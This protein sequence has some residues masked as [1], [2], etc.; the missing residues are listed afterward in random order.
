MLA[1]AAMARAAYQDMVRGYEQLAPRAAQKADTFIRDRCARRP[2]ARRPADDCRRRC[3]PSRSRQPFPGGGVGIAKIA[4]LDKGGQPKAKK[5]GEYWRAQE[6]G[7]EAHVGRIVPGFFM[8]GRSATIGRQFR[9]HPYFE[10]AKRGG[11]AG[12]RRREPRPWSS[13][14]RCMRAISCVTVR[15]PSRFGTH[16]KAIRIN[17]RA[18]CSAA[19]HA[20]L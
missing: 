6:Y 17:D 18:I 14:G 19:V 7:T 8:P 2:F 10:Q 13:R 20:A 1:E 9:N 12:R 4:T 15:L 5:K 16:S 11:A 3:T